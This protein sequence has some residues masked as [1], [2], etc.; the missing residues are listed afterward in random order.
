MASHQPALQCCHCPL[1][2]SPHTWPPLLQAATRSTSFAAE[3]PDE[4]VQRLGSSAGSGS[5]DSEDS[6]PTLATDEAA[7][8]EA[9]QQEEL[10]QR[11]RA[12]VCG[13]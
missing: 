13:G 8:A 6:L 2:H 9:A 11:L 7:A 5:P 1:P 10:E 3:Q 4:K 12:Q